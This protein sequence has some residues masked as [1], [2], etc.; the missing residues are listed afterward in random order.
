MKIHILINFP[1]TDK[2]CAFLCARLLRR[3]YTTSSASSRS[4]SVQAVDWVLADGGS[5]SN[6]LTQSN[7]FRNMRSSAEISIRSRQMTSGFK[8]GVPAQL[9]LRSKGIQALSIL[10]LWHEHNA[11]PPT[12]GALRSVRKMLNIVVNSTFLSFISA[13]AVSKCMAAISIAFQI[14]W[15]VCLHRYHGNIWTIPID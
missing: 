10:L 8:S 12:N 7:T 15:L 5:R 3:I 1:R 11:L 6:E 4:A 9:W 14:V 13:T 2:M